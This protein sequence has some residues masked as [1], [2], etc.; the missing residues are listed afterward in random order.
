MII[1]Y[2]TNNND[3]VQISSTDNRSFRIWGTHGTKWREYTA[4][5]DDAPNILTFVQQFQCLADTLIEQIG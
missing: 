4:T 3:T 2:Q 5:K 1:T